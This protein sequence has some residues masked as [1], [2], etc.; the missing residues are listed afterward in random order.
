MA[1]LQELLN[2]VQ[3]SFSNNYNV[4]KENIAIGFLFYSTIIITSINNN[5]KYVY[6][7]YPIARFLFD[8]IHYFLKYSYSILVN[9]R[10][11][12]MRSD[13]VASYV[14]SK[15]IESPTYLDN[16]KFFDHE[17][18]LL[19]SYEFIDTPYKNK[20][21]KLE[22]EYN[23]N[24]ICFAVNSF[25]NIRQAYGEGLV[26]MK[27]GNNYVYRVF[28]NNKKKDFTE[29]LM[30]LVPSDAK[31]LSI[32]YTHPIMKNSIAFDLGKSSYFVHNQLLSPTFIKLYLEQQSE[33]YHFDMDYV[34]KIMDDSLNMFELN[35]KK[36]ILLT[37]GGYKV[38]D[39]E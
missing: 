16:N 8:H 17:Y 38:V 27:L 32:E 33:L 10:I 29:F 34:V 11:E 13:W 15:A 36:S 39:N 18:M 35:S 12:P 6:N 4:L 5:Y 26:K 31:F 2:S 30:P 22:C 25:I 19:E 20:N 14:L 24:D 3:Y 21:D 9:K 23:Y 1:G 28:Y 7:K 37:I